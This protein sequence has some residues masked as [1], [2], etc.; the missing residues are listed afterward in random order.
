MGLESIDFSSVGLDIIGAIVAMSH[1]IIAGFGP[2]LA[3]TTAIGSH[4]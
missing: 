4:R 1:H 2:P 3:Y